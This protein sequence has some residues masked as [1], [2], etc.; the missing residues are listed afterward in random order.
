MGAPSLAVLGGTRSPGVVLGEEVTP[1]VGQG[2]AGIP[3]FVV[4][5]AP[6]LVGGGA[7]L[8]TVGPA[9]PI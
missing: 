9:R 3:M 8:P 6:W 1:I 4:G 5:T 7:G 2:L